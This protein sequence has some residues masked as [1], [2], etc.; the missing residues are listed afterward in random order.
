MI[1]PKFTFLFLF[2]FFTD[3]VW[4]QKKGDG[5]A[6]IKGDVIYLLEQDSEAE[7][8]KIGFINKLDNSRYFITARIMKHGPFSYIK[9]GGN[10]YYLDCDAAPTLEGD[11]CNDFRKIQPDTSTVKYG[12]S[13][14]KGIIVAFLLDSNG[15]I[16]TSGIARSA[17]DEYYDS[18]T[19]QLLKRYNKDKNVPASLHGK[20]ISYLLRFSTVFHQGNCQVVSNHN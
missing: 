1:N 4:A 16:V 6:D 15:D 20:P 12:E 11:I 5:K 10:S 7:K 2:I 9:I 3:P 19:L 18:K 8:I 14:A 13:M 17:N